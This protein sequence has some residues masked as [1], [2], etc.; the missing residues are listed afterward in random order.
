MESGFRTDEVFRKRRF[1]YSL[2]LFSFSTQQVLDKRLQR[3]QHPQILLDISTPYPK[4]LALLDSPRR[5][6]ACKLLAA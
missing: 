5:F 4:T 6:D 2:P 1:A 3:L